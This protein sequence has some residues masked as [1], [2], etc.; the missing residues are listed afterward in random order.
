MCA[1]AHPARGYHIGSQAALTQ[2][3]RMSSPVMDDGDIV[4]R[5]QR[6]AI[7]RYGCSRPTALAFAAGVLSPERSLLDYGC[8]YGGDVRWLRSKKIEA[9][10]WDP[11]FKPDPELLRDSD[12]VSLI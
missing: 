9:V 6:S 1:P 8:G 4:I 5:R 12:V 2:G 3:G 10:G 11:H 7:R